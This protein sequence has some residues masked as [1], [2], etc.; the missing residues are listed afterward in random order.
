MSRSGGPE[1]LALGTLEDLEEFHAQIALA[2]REGAVIALRDRKGG[3]GS[4]LLRLQ[5]AD[6]HKLARHLNMRLLDDRCSEAASQ[7]EAWIPRFPVIADVL[8]AWQNNRKLLGG[9][10]AAPDLAAA[11]RL[12]VVRGED[13]GHERI[14]RRESARL[15]G[16]SK[17]IEKLTP[18]LDVLL[19][20]EPSLRGRMSEELWA[21]I[22]LRREPQPLLLSGSGVVDLG[23]SQVPLLQPYL[24]LP[25]EL[26]RAVA[27]NAHYVLTIEN[28]ASFHDAASSG[29]LGLLIYTGGMP[30]PAWRAAYQRI[31]ISQPV[32]VPVY[33][34]GDIDEGGFRIAAVLARVANATERVVHPWM[35]SP[36]AL[37]ESVLSNAAKPRPA[38]LAAMCRWAEHAGWPEV[39][40]HLRARPILVEQEH[41]DA[42]LPGAMSEATVI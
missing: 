10:D 7:L 20:G 15:F 41:L 39:A 3:D 16:D 30:S 35:M 19:G 25:L 42:H 13:P 14:L 37:P 4:R 18:Y 33:H 21:E 40:V 34:W 9:P 12:I 38:V 32:Q 5:V 6:L 23:D 29:G 26:V 28:L 1:Y 22:G 36:S 11:A 31:L 27:A 8:E 24:G 2:E 17:R